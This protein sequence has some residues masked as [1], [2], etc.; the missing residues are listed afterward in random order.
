VAA[1]NRPVRAGLVGYGS[2]GET[3]HAPLIETTEGIELVA[4][5]TADP[6]RQRRARAAHRGVTL[7]DRAADLVAAGSTLG[8]DLVV[9]AAPNRAHVPVALSA[10]EAGYPVV[11]DKP[12]ATTA[13]A[14][15]EVVAVA[16]ARGLLL[17]V[18]QNRRWDG[19]FL[20]VRRLVE[21][22]ALGQVLRFESRFERWRPEP[23]LD[24]WREQAD[25]AEGGGLLLDLGSHLVD[26]ALVLFGPPDSVYAEV[27]R[28]RAGAT[29]DDDTFIALTHRGG[30]VS[31]VWASATAA[32]PG[33]RFRVLGDR[34][35]YVVYG[36][37]VQ[38]GALQGGSLP[39][40][41]GWGQVPVSQWGTL[42]VGDDAAPVP[43]EPGDYRRFYH[44]IVASLTE[45][46]PPPVLPGE[47]VTGLEVLDAARR[48]AAH[49]Q[50][51][52]L[53]R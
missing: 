32:R 21:E 42:G 8:L 27:T 24:A 51:V 22:G 31:H 38:E 16:A 18:F 37:D 7:L 49:G 14:A 40:S 35:G 33:P 46:G 50:V 23:R 39:G 13:A 43:T 9:V 25:P 10:L 11:V 44:G 41:A 48:S 53:D 26:Q 1:S 29:V 4:I 28:R 5:S 45:G 19:D 47:A 12:L 2:A 15:R 36:M 34:S 6:D 20:T 17:S 30:V 3:L 52:H